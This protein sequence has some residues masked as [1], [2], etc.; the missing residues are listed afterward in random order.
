MALAELHMT[1]H[2]APD[3]TT[4]RCSGVGCP[5]MKEV[6][7]KIGDNEFRTASIIPCRHYQSRGEP[8]ALWARINEDGTCPHFEESAQ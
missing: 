3:Y 8:A 6:E 1:A 4:T 2:P 7:R 5:H